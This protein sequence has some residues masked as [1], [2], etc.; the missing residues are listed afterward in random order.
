MCCSSSNTSTMGSSK[1]KAGG[2]TSAQ[3]WLNFR[4]F[5]HFNVVFRLMVV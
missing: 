3:C 1:E 4:S 2:L 5:V